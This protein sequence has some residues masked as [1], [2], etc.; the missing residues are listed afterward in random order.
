MAPMT[1]DR[2]QVPNELHAK[3]Y[4]QRSYKNGGASLIFSEGIFIEPQGSYW[5]GVPGLYTDEMIR[6]WKLV[7]DA[8]HANGSYIFAQLW[9]IGRLTHPLGNPNGAQN[10]GPSAVRSPGG[11]FRQYNDSEYVTP[12]A[13]STQEVKNYVKL[14]GEMAKQAKEAGFDGVEIHAANGY[15]PNQFLDKSANLRLDEYGCQSWDDRIRFVMEVLQAAITGFGSEQRVGIKLGPDT[16]NNGMV[17]DEENHPFYCYLLDKMSEAFPKLGYVTIMGDQRMNVSWFRNHWKGPE[18]V[19]VGNYCFD[20][21][22]ADR[23]LK[24]DLCEAFTFGR[25]FIPNPDLA[26]RFKHGLPMSKVNQQKGYYGRR[27]TGYSDYPSYLEI[28]QRGLF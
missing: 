9:H 16:P 3:Y 5:D 27:E 28:Q 24:A 7:T 13:L 10:I 22:S 17:V 4:A 25:P 19:L 8:V 20:A 6:G 23:F 14:Y 21:T 18:K 12:R 2:G 15:L 26:Y 1:R 11:R